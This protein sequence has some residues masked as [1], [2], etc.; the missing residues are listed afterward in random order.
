[1]RRLLNIYDNNHNLIINV[2]ETPNYL[3]LHG[4]TIVIIKSKK[5]INFNIYVNDKNRVSV[6]LAIKC[7]GYKFPPLLIFKG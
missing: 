3:E 4:K 5:E 6:I 7:K 1:M 2:D